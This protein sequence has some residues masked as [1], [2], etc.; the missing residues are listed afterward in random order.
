L[1]SADGKPGSTIGRKV[2]HHNWMK[3]FRLSPALILPTEE[4]EEKK[5]QTNG[6]SAAVAAFP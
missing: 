5:R 1:L 2:S 3:I 4:V 6:T